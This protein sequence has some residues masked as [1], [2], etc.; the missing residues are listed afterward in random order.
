MSDVKKGKIDDPIA[1]KEQMM[2][3]REFMKFSMELEESSYLSDQ[4]RKLPQPPL[5]KAAMSNEIISL[6]RNFEDLS[7][8]NDLFELSVL[9]QSDRN[10]TCE[11]ISLLA[12]SFMLW[13]TQGVKEI[14]GN[15][16]GTYRPVPSGGARHAFETY[17]IVQNVKDLK[18]GRYQYLPMTH[19]LAY[20]GENPEQ[21]VIGDSLCGQTWANKSDV[22]FYWS[23]VAYR[24]EWRYQITAHRTALIDA[25]HV[26]QN[27]YLACAAL[28]LGT[29]GIAAFN[30]TTCA[31]LFGYDSIN[32]YTIYT[33]TVGT[34]NRVPR[35]KVFVDQ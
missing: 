13:M 26:G 12:L 33:Q 29:C 20:L 22:V 21:S 34:V 30:E 28:D 32:E 2:K 25:G 9:R 19:S 31:K 7:K 1:A 4:E 3:N 27:L 24:C 16:Y 14:R 8:K 23:F 17:L 18:S 11:G 5:V 6:P 10:Y 15:N 35:S